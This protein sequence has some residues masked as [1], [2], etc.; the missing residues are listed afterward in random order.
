MEL[1]TGLCARAVTSTTRERRRVAP[2]EIRRT[3]IWPA[4]L[5]YWF[6]Y[7]ADRAD[8]GNLR[9]TWMVLAMGRLLALGFMESARLYSSTVYT[10]RRSSSSTS[11]WDD[12]RIL[13]ATHICVD[14]DGYTAYIAGLL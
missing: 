11:E 9:T 3:T 14:F 4:R 1:L 2:K 12:V 13:N 10:H 5:A 7:L 8:L 6:T